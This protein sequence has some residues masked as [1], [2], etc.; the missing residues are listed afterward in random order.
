MFIIVTSQ[1]GTHVGT[2]LGEFQVAGKTFLRLSG[3]SCLVDLNPSYV[4]EIRRVEA[5]IHWI[6][7][8][9]AAA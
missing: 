9:M 5:P 6:Q 4:V 7:G 3:E 2:V 8:P 1:G